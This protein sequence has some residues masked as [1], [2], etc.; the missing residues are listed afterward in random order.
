[1]SKRGTLI[2]TLGI[3]LEAE[4]GLPPLAARIYADLVLTD[5]QGLTF[6]DCQSNR[7]ASKGSVST[8]LNLLQKM[9]VVTY[10]TKPGDRKRHFTI[11]AR[12]AFFRSKLEEQQKKIEKDRAI[13][14]M[15]NNFNKQHNKAHYQRYGQ[16][17]E[18]YLDFLDQSEKLIRNSLDQFRKYTEGQE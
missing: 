3:H 14:E 13:I 9:G 1:M 4:Y 10:Y 15:V 16:R 7:G 17:T 6:D 12:K 2:E 18:L 5:D 11:A 8:A